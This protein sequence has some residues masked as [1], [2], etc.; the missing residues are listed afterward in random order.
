MGTKVRAVRFQSG[1]LEELERR[2]AAGGEDLSQFVNAAVDRALHGDERRLHA[3]PDLVDGSDF[4][5]C[6]AAVTRALLARDAR[7]ARALVEEIVH[8]GAQVVDVHQHVLRPALYEIGDRWSLEEVSVAQEHYATEVVGQLIGAL[9]P[10]R[11]LVPTRGRL[12]IVTSTPEELHALGARMVADVL[13]RAGWEVLALGAATPAED[14]TRLVS[15]ERPDLVA[16][17]TATI[18]RLPGVE[19][20]LV[21]LNV[22]EPRPA[23]VVGGALYDG[24][25]ADL[26]HEWGADLVSTDLRELLDHV[27]RR[28]PVAG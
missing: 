10:D 1:L 7:G 12:A 23:I 20:A 25:V 13:E 27:A 16:L 24:P 4:E 22:L 5:D 14:L 15:E 8:R 26:A 3:V 2:L 9:A 6:A 19:E 18:G 21:A 11:R 28:F 17:S